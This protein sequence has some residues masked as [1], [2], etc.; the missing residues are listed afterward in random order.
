MNHPFLFHKILANQ[1]ALACSYVITD[2]HRI[3][4]ATN[5]NKL[6]QLIFI[7]C[8]FLEHVPFCDMDF[9]SEKR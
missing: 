4:K 1:S 5:A 7:T 6:F 3:L 9:D 2:W 8:L